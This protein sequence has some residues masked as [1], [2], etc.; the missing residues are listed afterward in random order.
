[1]PLSKAQQ[2]F[3][4]TGIG[5]SESPALFNATKWAGPISLYESKV[6]KQTQEETLRMYLGT[7]LEAPLSKLYERNNPGATLIEPDTMRHPRHPVV[8]A[9]PD[10]LLFRGKVNRRKPPPVV[11]AERLVQFKTTGWREREEYGAPGTDQV[12]VDKIIQVTQEMA[13]T[14]V[15]VC[16]LA[17]LFDRDA[18]E[19]Y[20][21]RFDPELAEG[22]ADACERFWRDHVVPQRPPPPDASD[23][24]REFLGRL[25]PTNSR[26]ELLAPTPD[27]LAKVA[28][29]A[30][31]DDEIE[32]FE[33]IRDEAKNWLRAFIGD[34]S[35][36]ATP[37][38][39]I[40]FTKNKDGTK[41]NWEGMARDLHTQLALLVGQGPINIVGEDGAVQAL[42]LASLPELVKAFSETKP[43]N[44]PL[45]RRK[46]PKGK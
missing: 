34:A 2:A 4:R 23:R 33:T 15:H 22:I 26:A 32:R 40:D 27:V 20:T 38:F 39:R 16:D 11:E 24:Y 9:T 35:G 5:A 12:P 30:T 44:R 45:V 29:W 31:C 7:E 10:R 36:I 46:W 37:D 17:V 25:Y 18:F 13:V 3:R 21:I 19:I 41:V 14:G 1:M 42:D 8:L 6:M 28:A 43:G